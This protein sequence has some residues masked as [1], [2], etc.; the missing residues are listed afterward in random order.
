MNGTRTRQVIASAAMLALICTLLPA[1]PGRRG[2][3]G[4]HDP[5]D[6]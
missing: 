1:T 3:Q 2:F 4:V 5:R 6:P